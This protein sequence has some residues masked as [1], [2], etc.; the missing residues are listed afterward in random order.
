MFTIIGT[1]VIIIESCLLG[2]S[3]F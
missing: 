3:L 1:T 2:L